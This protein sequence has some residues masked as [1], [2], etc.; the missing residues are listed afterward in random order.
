VKVPTQSLK[1]TN[2]SLT[3]IALAVGY[4][5]EAAFSRALSGNSA[6]PHDMAARTFRMSCGPGAK[7]KAVGISGEAASETRCKVGHGSNADFR[8]EY[9][10]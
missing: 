3:Q 7:Q 1:E 8:G 10:S 9:L 5:S 4:E 2:D 6:A